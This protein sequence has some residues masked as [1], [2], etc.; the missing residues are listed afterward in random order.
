MVAAKSIEAAGALRRLMPNVGG[1]SQSKRALL[2][3]VVN[4]KL[5]YAAPTW[6]PKATKY[7]I[8]RRAITRALRNASQR[9]IRAYR[10]VS[11]DVALFLAGSLPGD[12]STLERAIVREKLHDQNRTESLSSIR[13]SERAITVNQ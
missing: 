10:T 6:A 13:K 11:A 7:D 4:S 8:N 2:M 5:F 12:L 1:P 9:T 3:S